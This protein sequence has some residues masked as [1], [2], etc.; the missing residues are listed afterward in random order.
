MNRPG[1]IRIGISG[2]TYAPWRGKFYPPGL[3]HK[4]ELPYASHALSSI[5]INGTFYSLQ[6]PHSFAKWHDQ[7]PPDF[8]FSIKAPR[9]ITHIRRLRDIKAPIANFFLSGVLCLNEKLGPILWQFPPNF[10]FDPALME[11]F[12]D[13][14]PKTT[15]AAARLRK[16]CDARMKDRMW[17]EVDRDRPISHAVEIRHESFAT[18]RW[19][20]L[21]RKYNVAS[22]VADTAGKWPMLHDVTADFV[23]VRLHGAEELYSSGYTPSALNAWAKKVKVWSLGG[24]ANAHPIGPPARK[25]ASRNIFVYFDN[26]IKVHAP[27]DAKKLAEKVFAAPKAARLP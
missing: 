21:L 11:Q 6:R 20:R 10:K 7:T 17:A 19:A 24:D 3:P 12:L 18:P 27:F 8:V 22:V 23:Y 1:K 9:Y 16:N 14:L 26:D 25:R 2:W 13:Q 15:A 5:E 4:D